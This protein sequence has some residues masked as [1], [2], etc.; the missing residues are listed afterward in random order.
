ME[1]WLVVFGIILL[2]EDSPFIGMCLIFAAFGAC[3]PIACS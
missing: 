1:F 2:L 3:G